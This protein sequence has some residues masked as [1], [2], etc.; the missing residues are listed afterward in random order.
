MDPQPARNPQLQCTNPGCGTH[1]LPDGT[2]PRCSPVSARP[3]DEKLQIGQ[4]WKD[5]RIVAQA[6]REIEARDAA[7]PHEPNP[8]AFEASPGARRPP[9]PEEIERAIEDEVT[10]RLAE[11]AEAPPPPA[12]INPSGRP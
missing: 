1:L 10:R 5:K 6:H 8:G 12:L 7:G 2:C 3:S 9:T 4:A 11:R